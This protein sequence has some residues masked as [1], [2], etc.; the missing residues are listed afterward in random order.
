MQ[1]GAQPDGLWRVEDIVN[2]FRAGQ[3]ER[4]FFNWTAKGAP[5]V[6]LGIWSRKVTLGPG[7]KIVLEAGCGPS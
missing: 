5:R 2:R 3:V 1:G 7:E 4:C 6:T